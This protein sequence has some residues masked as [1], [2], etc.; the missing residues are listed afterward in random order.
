MNSSRFNTVFR[1]LRPVVLALCLGLATGGIASAQD[2]PVVRPT[3]VQPEQRIDINGTMLQITQVE[4]ADQA[5]AVFFQGE[6]DR[7]ERAADDPQAH[8]YGLFLTEDMNSQMSYVVLDLAW[9]TDEGGRG[10]VGLETFHTPTDLTVEG[11]PSTETARIQMQPQQDGTYLARAYEELAKGSMVNNTD[12]GVREQY[13]TRDDSINA[14]TDNGPDDDESRAQ[15]PTPR[16][17]GDD[18]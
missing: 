11:I 1:G 5:S 15:G 14:R 8:P 2:Y 16:T 12:W 4:N 6:R 18:D 10:Y 3:D 13:T 17:G 9:L 7:F